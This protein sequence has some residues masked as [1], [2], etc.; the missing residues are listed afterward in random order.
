MTH[1]LSLAMRR[2][3]VQL[4]DRIFLKGYGLLSFAR[5]MDKNVGKNTS[6]N[7]SSKCSRKLLDHAKQSATDAIK[8]AS[9]IP[10]QKAAEATGDLIGN[11]IADKITRVSKTTPKNNIETNEEE[12]L[13]ERFIP[14]EIRQEIINDLRLKEE[15]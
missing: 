6:K 13:R 7:L 1:S 12:I 10:I 14:S 2:Y 11:K 9:K 5:N 8:T 3:S 15:N 4:K